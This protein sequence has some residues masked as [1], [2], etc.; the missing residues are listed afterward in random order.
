M[1]ILKVQDVVVR[2][3]DEA[4]G[5]VIALDCVSLSVASGEFVVALGASGCG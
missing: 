3:G 2:F 4:G 1:S 5:G